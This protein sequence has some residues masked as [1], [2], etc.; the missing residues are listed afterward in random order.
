M[1]WPALPDE[2]DGHDMTDS[3]LAELWHKLIVELLD[4][5]YIGRTHHNRRTYDAG[6][7]GPLC[8][9]AVREHGRRRQQVQAPS[10]R[11]FWIDQI[12]AY[13]H[14]IAVKRISDAQAAVLQKLTAS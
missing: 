13:W 14:P 1:S 12:I 6:C 7:K 2:L 3:E 11:Y 8:G 5:D 10:Q 4:T 9:K